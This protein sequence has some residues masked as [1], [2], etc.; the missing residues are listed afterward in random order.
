MKKPPSK[1]QRLRWQ[2]NAKTR[3]ERER[4]VADKRRRT[5]AHQAL[6]GP[7]YDWQG[8]KRGRKYRS[9]EQIHLPVNFRLSDNYD[10]VVECY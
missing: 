9:W 5:L 1:Y 8:S 7:K 10:K 6:F 3:L 4:E 2:E